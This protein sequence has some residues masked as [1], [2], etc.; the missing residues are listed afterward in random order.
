MVLASIGIH[1]EGIVMH[2]TNHLEGL[3]LRIKAAADVAGRNVNDITILPVSKRQS[4]D[5]VNAAV[6]AGCTAMGENYVQ[7]ALQK[8]DIL[9][10]T[11]DWH[12]IG[13][14]QANKTRAIAEHF[15][16]AHTVMSARVAERLSKQ[17]P[18]TIAPLNICVQVC[19]DP[20]LS[21]G[22][23]AAA[24]VQPLCEL[25]A[26]LPR[27]RLRGL[28]VLPMAFTDRDQQR[29]PFRQLHDLYTNLLNQGLELDTLSMGMS[30]DLEAAIMEG[31]TM[32]RIG[33]ALFGARN[34]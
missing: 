23:C 13:Q 7:E 26:T 2:I 14:L 10:Q 16:W 18:D 34:N 25:I 3:Q 21:H 29:V 19:T 31:S 8:I 33:T 5:A 11:I 20:E 28:M 6:T 1:P 27:L 30:G 9:G 24:D 22:G 15:S 12:F 4:V 32:I 17:R